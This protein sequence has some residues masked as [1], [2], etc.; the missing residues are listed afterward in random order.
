MSD[1][2]SR[3]LAGRDSS[4]S[5]AAWL[6][7]AQA[8]AGDGP[9]VI[10]VVRDTPGPRATAPH[11]HARGQLLGARRGLLTVGS[12]RGRW[13]VPPSDAVWI[14]P[15]AEHSLRSHG[16][17]F[18]GWSLYVAADACAAL[19]TQPCGLRVP[20]LLREIVAR[21]GDGAAPSPARTRLIAVA[22][23]EI[24]AAA[25]GAGRPGLPMPTD[26]RLLKIAQA[27]IEN[28][29]DPRGAADWAAWAHLSERSL[30]R[31]FALETGY[32]LRQWRQRAGL[33]SAVERLAAGAAVT[34]VA[35]DSGYASV[36]AFGAMFR[37]HFGVSPTAYLEAMAP[38]GA[39]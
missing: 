33:L 16:P 38:D 15:Q 22:L 3:G 6:S 27:L 29:A 23:D 24:A 39:G 8:D 21:L 37:R 7:A 20:A 1:P 13:L 30:R 26:P 35:L 31:H 25:A 17:R 34:A 14:P 28:P 4:A 5:A 11:R 12:E 36:S 19:P 32:G 10:A 2:H 18:A 9:A